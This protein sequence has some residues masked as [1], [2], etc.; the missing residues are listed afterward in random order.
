[1]LGEQ[2]SMGLKDVSSR[3]RARR[4][5]A[6]AAA[7]LVQIHLPLSAVADPW[8]RERK[9]KGNRE[10]RSERPPGQSKG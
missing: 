4:A 6:W 5:G 7:R 3:E 10:E 2:K 1:M 8:G 9:G